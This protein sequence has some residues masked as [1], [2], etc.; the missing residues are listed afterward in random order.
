MSRRSRDLKNFA[1]VERE[2]DEEDESS[3]GTEEEEQ[4]DYEEERHNP[5]PQ[6]SRRISGS[7]LLPN[8]SSQPAGT[9]ARKPL[10]IPLNKDLV[11]HVRSNAHSHS[12]TSHF[13]SQHVVL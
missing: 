6:T 12:P 7:G 11:C 13:Q 10:K 8:D 1:L 2:A 3:S 5:A 9:T 4:D